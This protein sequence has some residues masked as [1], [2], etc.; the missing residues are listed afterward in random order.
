MLFL[1]VLLPMQMLSGGMTPME[2]MPRWVQLVMQAA[3]TTHFVEFSQAI[4]FR[5]AGLEVV[6]K[7]F[8]MLLIIGTVLFVVSLRSFRKSI[9]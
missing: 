7:P 3:P 1:L 2:S 6:W 4:L 5:G 9:A 8:V